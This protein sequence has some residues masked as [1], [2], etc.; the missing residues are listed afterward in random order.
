MGTQRITKTRR[1]ERTRVE[2]NL[3]KQRARVGQRRRAGRTLAH[4]G[5]AVVLDAVVRAE[6]EGEGQ[7]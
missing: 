6:H 2:S 1:R 7:S 4:V 3:E 5:R